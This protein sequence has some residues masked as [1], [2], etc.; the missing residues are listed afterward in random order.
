MELARW[1]FRPEE[2]CGTALCSVHNLAKDEASCAA[3]AYGRDSWAVIFLNFEIAPVSECRQRERPLSIDF[4]SIFLNSFR[5][6]SAIT[7]LSVLHP[8]ENSNLEISPSLA[9]NARKLQLRMFLYRL[10]S[11]H[12]RI[13]NFESHRVRL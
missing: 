10:R 9:S 6:S 11:A 3:I 13:E 5:I 8:V 4:F 2:A 7:G 12:K 1:K